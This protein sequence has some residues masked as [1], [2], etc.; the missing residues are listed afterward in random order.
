MF[1]II[2]GELVCDDKQRRSFPDNNVLC[3]NSRSEYNGVR[4]MKRR[5]PSSRT[6]E[7]LEFFTNTHYS[8]SH[9]FFF[10]YLLK[11]KQLICEINSG[12]RQPG[13]RSSLQRSIILLYLKK[14]F[15]PFINYITFYNELK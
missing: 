12:E 15:F 1:C 8:F 7:S 2:S 3:P 6:S 13:N 4:R 10:K 5:I 14:I 9:S 11:K